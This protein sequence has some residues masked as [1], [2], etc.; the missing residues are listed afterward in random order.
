MI[1]VSSQRLLA[2][3]QKII[4]ASFL[5]LLFA[6]PLVLTPWNHELFE[7]NK[8]MLTY[9][10]AVVIAAAWLAQIVLRG[11]F[12]IRRTPL[13]VFLILFLASQVLSTIFS[14][15]PHTS[16][17]GYYS[18]FHGGLLSTISYLILYWG[19]TTHLASQ[20]KVSR[21]L[22]VMLASAFLV[23]GYGILEHFGI[24]ADHWVQDVQTRVFSTLGQPNWLAAFLITL[25]PVPAAMLINAK[26]GWRSR[27]TLLPFILFLL[28]YLALLFTKSRS[29]LLGFA[30]MYGL[31]WALIAIPGGLTRSILVQSQAAR[32]RFLALTGIILV[33]TFLVG[34][35]WSPSLGQLSTKVSRGQVQEVV[36]VSAPEGT[37][38][39]IGGTESGEIRKIVWRGAIDIWR[40]YPLLGSGVETF[41]YSYY[42]FR[43]AAHNL[44]SE[45]EF[46]YNKAHNEY[47]NF[48]ATSGIF[49]LGTLLALMAAYGWWSLK[50]IHRSPITIHHSLIPAFFS[51]FFGLAVT[52]FFGFSVVP[53]ALLFFLYPAFAFTLAD[54]LGEEKLITFPKERLAGKV[55]KIQLAGV[56]ILSLVTFYLLL[57]LAQRWR[58]DVAYAQSVKEVR[59]ANFG[60]ALTAARQAVKLVPSEPVYRDELA[61]IAANL[62]VSTHL[63]Q[64]AT[65]SAQL[66]ELARVES[67]RVIAANPYNLNFAKSRTRVF[68]KLAEIDPAYNQQALEAILAAAEL[69]PTDAKVIYNLGLMYGRV[70][71]GEAAIESLRQAAELKPDYR[72]AYFALVLFLREAGQTDEAIK[73]LEYILENI[74]AE[75]NEVQTLLDQWR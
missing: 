1:S 3:S 28:F 61:W 49:G 39:A 70:G 10:G 17:W 68:A 32:N 42:N 40:A 15:D 18:R 27:Q 14:L 33:I 22:R 58:A 41:A 16:L 31:F 64:Q 23:A 24:D 13:D 63:A 43:P 69:A 59:A 53:V 30:V 47:L 66:A 55:D 52:N 11:Q 37:Q 54:Q 51:G 57:S 62:A 34:S 72:D 29:G 50:Q 5:L 7:F 44:V 67:N 12:F 65:L 74:S 71:D 38:L 9:A 20:E 73:Q 56:I 35:P 75:D 2:I 36:P 21:A 48:L 25:A 60:A 4:E 6:V 26:E 45:W 46:L 8:M 19:F